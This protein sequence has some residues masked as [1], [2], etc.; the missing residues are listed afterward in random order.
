MVLY[1]SAVEAEL[2]VPK[3]QRAGARP[4]VPP[5]PRLCVSERITWPNHCTPHMGNRGIVKPE[6]FLRLPEVSA[7]HVF[8]IADAD[9]CVRVEGIWIVHR[10]KPAGHVP[11]VPT[12]L[13]V[14]LANI[15]WRLIA[16][17]EVADISLGI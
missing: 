4:L 5:P 12:G 3:K 15:V 9:P 16:L 6:T 10:D 1:D 17:S 13:L 7:N 11:F 8:E 2:S 14:D